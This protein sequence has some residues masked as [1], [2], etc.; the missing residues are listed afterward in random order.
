MIDLSQYGFE[1]TGSCHCD[2]VHTE[3]YRAGEY[4]VRLRKH[5][6]R[7]RKKGHTITQWIPMARLIDTISD[8]HVFEKA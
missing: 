3:K 5:S 7:I 4:E 2:G 1:Y 8:L 6:F